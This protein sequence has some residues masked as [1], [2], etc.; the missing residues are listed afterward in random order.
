MFTAP[1]SSPGFG[2]YRLPILPGVQYLLMNIKISL[3]SDFSQSLISNKLHFI[4]F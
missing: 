1:L 3:P 2:E 4:D